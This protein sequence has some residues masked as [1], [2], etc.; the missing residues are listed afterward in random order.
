MHCLRRLS[1]FQVIGLSF[2]LLIA[3]GTLLL[4][5]PWATN[6]GQGAGLLSAAFTAVSA[7][8]VTGLTVEDTAAY[9]SFFGQLVI[10]VLI[11]IGGL[12][13]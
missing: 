2:A 11:Q 8:C 13:S 10:L 12:A 9:W 3:T 4:M 5:T 6:D 7:S 1:S